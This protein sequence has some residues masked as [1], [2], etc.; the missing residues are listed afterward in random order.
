M[1]Y[2]KPRNPLSK[3]PLPQHIPHL[4]LHYE[5]IVSL[6]PLCDHPPHTALGI[7][8]GPSSALS[9][10]VRSP[11]PDSKL[12]HSSCVSEA[13]YATSPCLVLRAHGH[14]QVRGAPRKEQDA[15]TM[16]CCHG[17]HILPSWG[18]R[19]GCHIP[20]SLSPGWPYLLSLVFFKSCVYMCVCASTHGIYVW[21]V[22]VVYVSCVHMGYVWVYMWYLWCKCS[23]CICVLRGV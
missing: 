13:N 9:P 22:Y 11:T 5:K 7:Q 4:S 12:C 10:E 14:M 17:H 16:C 21:C 15:S 18:D 1:I 8:P 23:I 20:I 19:V 3:V 2:A 6:V